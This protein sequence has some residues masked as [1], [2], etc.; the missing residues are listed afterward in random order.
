M[1]VLCCVGRD[2][3]VDGDAAPL[4][5]VAA[6]LRRQVGV[7]GAL[8][9]G[10]PVFAAKE[11]KATGGGEQALKKQQE[12]WPRTAFELFLAGE[13]IQRVKVRLPLY[14]PF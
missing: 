3:V 11:G 14:T 12:G 9:E 6:L 2:F 7:F 8:V 4:A 5:D 10:M 13:Q 1:L